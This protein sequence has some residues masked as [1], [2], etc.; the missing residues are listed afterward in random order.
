MISEG[1]TEAS[2]GDTQLPVTRRV[3]AKRCVILSV[4]VELV[5]SAGKHSHGAHQS[6][7]FPCQ[8]QE[9]VDLWGLHCFTRRYQAVRSL[10]LVLRSTVFCAPLR[11]SF[12]KWII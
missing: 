9:V 2:D 10:L 5:N 11:P 12:S 6:G 4:V 3:L 8:T 1:V 7:E